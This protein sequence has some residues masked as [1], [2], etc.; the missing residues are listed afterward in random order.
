MKAVVSIIVA[1]KSK[2]PK[3][4]FKESFDAEDDMI[5]LNSF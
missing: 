3:A 4:R 5:E 1:V 2:F